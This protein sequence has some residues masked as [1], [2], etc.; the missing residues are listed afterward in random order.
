MLN[1]LVRV[2]LKLRNLISIQK[3]HANG[4]VALITINYYSGMLVDY[5]DFYFTNSAFFFVL[6][7]N[8]KCKI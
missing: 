8:P 5:L 4:Y 7:I 1:L 3:I 6:I 2:F